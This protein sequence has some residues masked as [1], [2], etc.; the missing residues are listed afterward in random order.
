[1][2]TLWITSVYSVHTRVSTHTHASTH[3]HRRMTRKISKK[4]RKKHN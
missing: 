1:M 2:P 3:L 4:K